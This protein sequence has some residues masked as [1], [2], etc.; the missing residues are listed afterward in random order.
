M[1][2]EFINEY[3]WNYGFTVCIISYFKMD[4]YR[5]WSIVILGLGVSLVKGKIKDV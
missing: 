1:R 4:E 2:I 5:S 3:R